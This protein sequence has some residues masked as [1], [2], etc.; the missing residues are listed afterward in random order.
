MSIPK[1]HHGFVLGKQG[2]KLKQIEQNTN[3]KIAMPKPDEK[4]DVIKITGNREDADLARV[5]IKAISEELVCARC[6]TLFNNLM[7]SP[8]FQIYL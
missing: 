8:N 3:T 7:D 5:E 6:I 1:E 4:S 2:A